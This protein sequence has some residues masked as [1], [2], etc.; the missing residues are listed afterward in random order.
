MA[1]SSL[2]TMHPPLDVTGRTKVLSAGDG[3]MR[4]QTHRCCQNNI[5][6][7]C[8]CCWCCISTKDNKSCLTITAIKTRHF[9]TT[10]TMAGCC[11]RSSYMHITLFITPHTFNSQLIGGSGS[12]GNLGFLFFV[13]FEIKFTEAMKYPQ[14]YSTFVV[15][16]LH[17]V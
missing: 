10:T 15:Y 3:P 14:P 1:P 9:L 11:I 16:S 7:Y 5:C 6:Y 12:D 17:V 2:T 8:H 13:R 4:I